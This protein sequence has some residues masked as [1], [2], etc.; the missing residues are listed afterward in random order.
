[1][2]DFLL[3]EEIERERE[4]RAL[5]S[6]ACARKGSDGRACASACFFPGQR[7]REEREKER[8]RREEESEVPAY[9]EPQK[10]GIWIWDDSR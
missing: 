3:Q 10:V 2:Q 6:V 4:R 9:A 8:K 5:G 1:M 7:E